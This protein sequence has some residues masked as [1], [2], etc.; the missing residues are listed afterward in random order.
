M[1]EQ[2]PI[3]RRSR[4]SQ[5]VES[6]ETEVEIKQAPVPT[7]RAVKSGTVKVRAIKHIAEYDT[8]GNMVHRSPGDEFEIDNDRADAI[9]G[10]ITRL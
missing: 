4:A 2:Q 6:E 8:K 5:K 3:R 7:D 9:I 10:L 1:N